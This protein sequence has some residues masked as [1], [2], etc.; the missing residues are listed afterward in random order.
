[1]T[2]A[3]LIRRSVVVG[4]ELDALHEWATEIEA[5]PAGS[6]RWGHYAERTPSGDVICRTENVSACHGGIDA[7]VGGPLHH[8]A[9]AELGVDTVAFKDKINFKQP[10]GAGF[11]PHQDLAAY[12]GASRVMSVLLAIDACTLESGCLWI[13]AG[14]DELL[15]TDARGVVAPDVAST[16][17]WSPAELAPGDAVCVAGLTPHYSEAN[18]SLTPRRV[19]VA[20]YASAQDGYDRDRYYAARSREMAL[21]SA[22]DAQFRISTLADFEGIEVDN[23]GSQAP[24]A[25][26]HR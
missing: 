7:V 9:E 26:W 8:V 6:H 15:P 1:M 14:V 23:R 10:G 5:W 21:A 24:E 12:P 3:S 22:R 13:A 17:P 2:G 20:S 18:R 4:P 25:C 19:L 11:S 16:L